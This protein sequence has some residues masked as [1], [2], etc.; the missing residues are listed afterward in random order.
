[1]PLA[2]GAGIALLLVLALLLWWVVRAVRKPKPDVSDDVTVLSSESS[3]P[4]TEV[5]SIPKPSEPVLA[6]LV[7]LDADST[8]HPITK[9]A[10]R[11]GR[12]QDNDLVMK[13]DTVSGHHAEILKRGDQF[14]IADLGASNGVFVRGKRVEK[15]PLENGDIIELG[16]VRLRFTLNQSDE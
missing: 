7:N 5:T 14:M 10:M 4:T 1:M 6:W 9:T 3:S 12:K 8:R 15:T 16:E 2:V 11:I 13:N